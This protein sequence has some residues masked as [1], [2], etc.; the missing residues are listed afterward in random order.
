MIGSGLRAIRRA[1][2]A[3]PT[4]ATASRSMSHSDDVRLRR[5]RA[6]PTACSS[7]RA[8]SIG[9]VED[10]TRSEECELRASREGL[11]GAARLADWRVVSTS[12]VAEADVT[13]SEREPLFS[14]P[15]GRPTLL[16]GAEADECGEADASTV[17]ADV[18]PRRDVGSGVP[19]ATTTRPAFDPRTAVLA[20][21][22][23]VAAAA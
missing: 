7:A 18:I 21:S 5:Q 11:T 1:P 23:A 19:D 4:S 22:S 12:P 17:A 14:M 2:T 15:A 20:P 9:L 13:T 3:A 10:P 8:L 16:A 6:R